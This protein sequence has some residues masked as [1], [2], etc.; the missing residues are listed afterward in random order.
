M[1]IEVVI[2]VV[3]L[4]VMLVLVVVLLFWFVCLIGGYLV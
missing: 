1:W 4:V 2:D 3:G